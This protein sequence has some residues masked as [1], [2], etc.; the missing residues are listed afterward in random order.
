M[1]GYNQGRTNY[2]PPCVNYTN[3]NIMQYIIHKYIARVSVEIEIED[4]HF[5][6]LSI[7]LSIKCQSILSWRNA[8]FGVS[9][10]FDLI[11]DSI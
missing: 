7:L 3:Q 1:L 11:N 8:C 2:Q 6:M 10:T 9:I 5:L 4:L